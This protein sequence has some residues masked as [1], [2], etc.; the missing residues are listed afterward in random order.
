MSFKKMATIV[1]AMSISLNCIATGFANTKFDD[2]KDHWAEN[3]IKEFI[4]AGY[5]SGY[6]DGSFKPNK[7]ITRAE[8]VSFTNK[9]FGFKDIS[10]I[11]F[12]DVTSKDWFYTEVK[13]AVKAGYINGY[14]DNTFRPNDEIT[15]QEIANIIT[16]IHKRKD[17]NFDKIR[18]F[19]DVNKISEWAKSSVEGAV[20][21]KYMSGYE[22]NTFRPRDGATRAEAVSTLS[23]VPSLVNQKAG[24]L[25]I[26]KDDYKLE[27]YEPREGTYLGAYILQD[28]LIN[29]DMSTFEKLT[30]KKHASYFAYLGYKTGSVE[31]TKKWMEEV[32]A[33]G[34]IPHL[35]VEPNNGLDVV[36]EDEYLI[37]L[38]KMFGELDIPI[39]LRFASEMNGDWVA[40]N[41]DPAK[42]IE[43]WR[44]V[45][46]V[47]EK[48]APKVMML[49][50]PFTTPQNSIMSYYPG[51]EYVDWVGVNV[52]NVVY[53]NN[54]LNQ[55]A[56]HEDPLE[57]L[58]YVYDTFSARKPI[59]ISEYGATH[60]TITDDKYYVDF[61]I[62]KIER[63]YSGIWEKYPRIKSI[64]YFDVNNLVNAPEGRKINNY[65]ITD[66][67]RITEAYKKII[68][69]KSFL[70]HIKPNEAGKTNNEIF[71]FADEI[72]Q[73]NNVKYINM[74]N[75]KTI[76]GGN[77]EYSKG[78]VKYSLKGK[79]YTFDACKENKYT[80]FVSLESFAKQLGYKIEKRGS[81]DTLILKK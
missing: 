1:L 21:N 68:S 58:D 65:A 20:E 18:N 34:S 12:T 28:E 76:L 48:Y 5:I 30:G 55:P 67:P 25:L 29:A 17:S 11:Q 33:N 51:D 42:Y 40:W 2:V 53:H 37:N 9:V 73:I 10:D 44:L 52:Y 23:R 71:T 47:M 7:K 39:Y 41:G 60:Y 38:A 80:K 69:N 50:T 45:H 57:L 79:V 32:K 75:A 16:S 3:E 54:S 77:V 24:T 4:D 61:A 62:E 81:S 64:F 74:E 70:D 49:W 15:R 46:D 43:K 63:M 19:K 6:E 13:R 59:Q 31:R 27:K 14:E 78:K 36:V 26:E 35:A 8:F 66:E 72:V 22:D 56:M